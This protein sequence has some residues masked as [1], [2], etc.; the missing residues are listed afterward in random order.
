M[1]TEEL[2]AYIKKGRDAGATPELLR[3][4]LVQNGWVSADITE[5]FSKLGILEVPIIPT[6]PSAPVAPKTT[7]IQPQTVVSQTTPTIMQTKLKPAVEPVEDFDEEVVIKESRR[8]HWGLIMTIIFLV[9]AGGGFA[10]GYDAGYFLTFEKITDEAWAGARSSDSGTFDT[11]IT[12]DASDMV[13]NESGAGALA[14]GAIAKGSVTL[15]GSYD[16][17]TPDQLFYTGDANMNFGTIKASADLRI[18]DQKLFVQLKEMTSVGLFESAEYINKWISFDYK[19]DQNPGEALSMLPFGGFNPDTI[20]NITPEQKNEILDITNNADFII[21]AEK[22][23]PEKINDTLSYHFMFDLDREGVKN[24]L[25][26]FKN[27]LEKIGRNDSYLSSIDPT[28]LGEQLDSITD[29]RGEAWVGIKDNLPY[30]FVVSFGIKPDASEP[31]TVKISIASV[32]NNWNQPL[33]VEAPTDAMS[34]EEFIRTAFPGPEVANYNVED[35]D[36]ATIKGLMS[37]LRA[38]AE[39]YFDQ[40]AGYKD[41]C[42]KPDDQ[43][44]QQMSDIAASASGTFMCRDSATAYAISTMLKDEQIF[45]VDSTGFAGYAPSLITTET[46]CSK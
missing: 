23:L 41:F 24:Y 18:A 46:V 14:A 43:A 45:C 26:E 1:I 4:K 17:G 7:P 28:D 12:I 38:S 19:S 42:M 22:M 30:K 27:Y 2:L 13:S 44:R 10:Y 31:D 20:R 3:T 16:V 39:I 15:R 6:A 36:D 34:L 32:F 21:V 37:S 8:G 40:T 9:V 29:F 33:T 25:A 5:A 11:T 35:M